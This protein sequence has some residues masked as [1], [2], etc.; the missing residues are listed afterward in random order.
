MSDDFEEDGNFV[1][2]VIVSVGL[3]YVTVFNGLVQ[4]L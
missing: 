2:A 3:D 1:A 4:G